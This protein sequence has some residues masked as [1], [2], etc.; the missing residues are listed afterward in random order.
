MNINYSEPHYPPLQ[1]VVVRYEERS[2]CTKENGLKLAGVALAV[3][4]VAFIA[5]AY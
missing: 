2:D 1:G 5:L 4:V 3:V